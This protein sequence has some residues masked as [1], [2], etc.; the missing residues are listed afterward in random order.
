MYKYSKWGR[1]A[2][3]KLRVGITFFHQQRSTDK[4]NKRHLTQGT[5]YNNKQFSVGLWFCTLQSSGC[6]VQN[7]RPADKQAHYMPEKPTKKYGKTFLTTRMQQYNFGMWRKMQLHEEAK[8][9]TLTIL[10]YTHFNSLVNAATGT[11]TC[12]CMHMGLTISL[13]LEA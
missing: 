8:F 3:V 5:L 13:P 9:C 11:S 12:G 4:C 2:I 10:S 7:H 1:F 6:K